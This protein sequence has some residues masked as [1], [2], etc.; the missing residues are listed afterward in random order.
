MANFPEGDYFGQVFPAKHILCP[1]ILGQSFTR[2]LG[3][4]SSRLRPSCGNI[5]ATVL[6]FE[7]DA[8][9][10]KKAVGRRR[11][12]TTR[13]IDFVSVVAADL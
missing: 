6:Q 1:F 12:A 8:L 2:K 4:L 13:G 3:N 9:S 11:A 10:H 5:R 7:S